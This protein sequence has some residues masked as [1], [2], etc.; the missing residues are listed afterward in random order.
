MGVDREEVAFDYEARRCVYDNVM[1]E[2][3][4]PTI[5]EAAF[6][7]SATTDDV[8]ASFQ[9]LADGH[10]LVLQKGSGEILSL[11]KCWRLAKAWYGPDR[12]EPGWRRRNAEE[13]KA[14]FAELSLTTPFWRLPG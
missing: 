14:L 4:P 9:R 8:R 1:R 12:R 11:A 7:L 10:V 3:L 2:G 13:T 6:A 5:A